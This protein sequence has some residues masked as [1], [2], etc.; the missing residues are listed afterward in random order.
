MG[1]S[2]SNA[3]IP[4]NA[5]DIAPNYA[6][7]VFGKFVLLMMCIHLIPLVILPYF[8]KRKQKEHSI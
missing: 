3:S 5:Q 2:V 1:Q 8:S 6:G 7:S 4:P